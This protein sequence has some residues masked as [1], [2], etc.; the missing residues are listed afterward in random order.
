MSML[1]ATFLSSV[2]HSR[3]N[4]A[5]F[6]LLLTTLFAL[7]T[8]PSAHAQAVSGPLVVVPVIRTTAGN[9]NIGDSGDGYAATSAALDSPN[10]VAVDP[11]GNIYDADSDSVRMVAAS[12]GTILGQNVT[13]GNIYTV[14]GD[15][16]S[17]Y[18]GDGGAATSA[19]TN[20]VSVATDSAG[21]LYIADFN[22]NRIRVVAAST[23]T[24]F[25]QSVTA[26]DI[27]TVAGN[28]TAGYSGD[29]GAATS[30]EL[31]GPTGVAVDSAGNLYI[32]DASNNR[33]RV[34]AAS[35]Q[36]LWGQSMTANNIYTIAGVGGA[37]GFAGDGGA[38]TNAKLAY[39]SNL[40]FDNWGNLYITDFNNSCIRMIAGSTRTFW[41]QNMTAN[42]IYTITGIT[43]APGY[44]GDGITATTAEVNQPS[45]VAVDSSGNLYIADKGNNRIRVVVAS[46]GMLWGQNV[47]AN[48]IYT[49]VGNGTGGYNGDGIEA[50]NSELWLPSG[51]AF[52]ST[53]N[54]YVA[55]SNNNR[56]R[57]VSPGTVMPTTAVGET[58][59]TQNV[60]VELTQASAISSISVPKAMNGAQEFT[61]GT[62]TG[63]TLGT[64]S[65]PIN[66]VCTVPITFNP[67]YPGPRTGA[68]TF[69]SSGTTILGTVGLTGIGTGPQIVFPS[70]SIVFP[71]GSKFGEPYGIEVDTYGDVFVADYGNKAV[72]E[73]MAGTGGASAGTVNANSTVNT[74]GSG[75]YDP[76]GVAVDPL[77]DV[78][79]A[80]N[81]TNT[82]YEIMAGTG[83]AANGT[84]NANSTVT[85]IGTFAYP[86]SLAVDGHGNVFIAGGTVEEILAGTGGAAN[87]T[88]NANSTVQT[89]NSAHFGSPYGIAVD[90]TGDVFVSDTVTGAVYEILAGTGGAAAGTVNA[91]STVT[92]IGSGFMTPEGVAVDVAGDVFV[93]DFGKKTVYEIMSGTGGAAIGTVNV[94]STINKIGSGMSAPSG[95]ALNA[96]GDV[97][98]TDNGKQTVDE[99]ALSTPP[100]ITFASTAVGNTSSDSPQ[101]VMVQNIGNA[102]LVF[103]ALAAT[104]NFNLNGT[105]TTCSATTS[106]NIG[107]A[108]DL[109]V[110][111]LPTAVGALTGTVNITD[112]SLNAAAAMQTISLS[113]TGTT[114]PPPPPAPSV[115]ISFSAATVT[116]SAPGQSATDTITLTP[117][118]GY[119]GTVTLACSGLPSEAACAFSPASVTFS[120]SSSAEQTVTLTVTTTAAVAA[121]RPYAP[122]NNHSNPMPMLA[123]AFWLPGL[124][125]AGAGLRKKRTSANA[126][127]LLHLLVLLV[128]LAG[129][130]MM[131]ACGG[132]SSV[133][134]TPA[135]NPGTP[136]GSSK[137]TVTITGTGSLSQSA[138]FTLAVQ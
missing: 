105:N 79:V 44:N 95:V 2:A 81:D 133:H 112:N 30:A 67:Q 25:G 115:A 129:A 138:T 6:P 17:G 24:L 3:H 53:G 78:L 60:Y 40:A 36:T 113:G 86:D 14:A 87:G 43:G 82:L 126:S 57:V 48:D 34:V 114:P 91:N 69:Y 71:V 108:C 19:E 77:G 27:Y 28:G 93:G 10:G 111:F 84:V 117:S 96:A 135:T 68:L 61:V 127:R 130:G 116:V 23:G 47:T 9:G 8:Y 90:T 106:L 50:T 103:S 59:A 21:N 41:G 128:L 92:M 89:L 15:G 124:L 72:Y 97:F 58:A 94:S 109:G 131:T 85:K 122:L 110:E 119:A 120:A 102:P 99:I 39:P 137:V 12:H 101:T 5:V 51:V 45:G 107:A 52:D 56:I 31:S 125:A 100:V 16:S 123:G 104:T 37:G 35:T 132:S 66:T 98:V 38:A 1:R 70:N 74:V 136:T 20:T 11:A 42:D 121:L 32:A 49:V 7:S 55:D 75:F 63:C 29:G 62:V 13:A 54:L 83:G 64:T 73:V 4:R 65:N 134:P 18:S 80:D 33:V 26:G 88:V 46:T 76:Y 118:G 22:N